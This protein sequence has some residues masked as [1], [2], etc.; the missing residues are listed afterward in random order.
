MKILN[1][2]RLF[3]Q[4]LAVLLVVGVVGC[5]A[6]P[7][8]ATEVRYLPPSTEAGLACLQGCHIDMQAC[9]ADCE[10][11]RQA[12]IAGIEPKVEVAFEQ[13]LRDYEAER[14]VYMR[15]RQYYQ[16]DRSLRFG[17]FRDPFYYGYPGSHYYG[18]PGPFWYTDYYFDH[19]PIPPVAPDRA[20]IR[21]HLIEVECD[22]NCDCQDRFDQCYIGCGG[23][24]ERR[25]VCVENCNGEP[26]GSRT[27]ATPVLPD[28]PANGQRGE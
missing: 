15:E 28:S 8:Y 19:P 27:S 23:Q 2:Y 21:S 17:A 25:V 12:C 22:L 24:V 14:R 1:E 6:G 9:L 13:A 7:R 3:W 10:S 16:L 4:A 5:A 18:Y 11:R 26:P 20:T